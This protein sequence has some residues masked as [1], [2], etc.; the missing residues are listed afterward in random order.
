MVELDPCAVKLSLQMIVVRAI[1]LN[2][3]AFIDE[4]AKLQQL[5]SEILVVASVHITGT[6]QTQHSACAVLARVADRD[7][8]LFWGD[9]RS[10]TSLLEHLLPIV[11]MNRRYMHEL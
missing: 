7:G 1:H 2:R 11:G 10:R 5:S 3:S 4:R 6:V 8:T 9:Y